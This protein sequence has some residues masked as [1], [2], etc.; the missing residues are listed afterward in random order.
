MNWKSTIEQR[1]IEAEM[2]RKK[3]LAEVAT[4]LLIGMVAVGVVLESWIHYA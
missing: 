1:K 4:V 3:Q 2:R